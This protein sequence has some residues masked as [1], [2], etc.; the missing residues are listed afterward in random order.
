[1]KRLSI[2]QISSW[3][4]DIVII[5][6]HNRFLLILEQRS[7][8]NRT[9]TKLKFFILNITR[10]VYTYFMMYLIRVSHETNDYTLNV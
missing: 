9:I 10:T 4:W 3:T 8:L 5:K 2:S 6:D 1:M 7:L